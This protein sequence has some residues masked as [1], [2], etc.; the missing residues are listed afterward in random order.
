MLA[1]AVLSNGRNYELTGENGLQLSSTDAEVIDVS[2][3]QVTVRGQ[4]M[5]Q[6]LVGGI[7]RSVCAGPAFSRMKFIEI[8]LSPVSSVEVTLET[9]TLSLAQYSEMLATPSATPIRIE[10][11]HEDGSRTLVDTSDSRIQTVHDDPLVFQNGM[12]DVSQVLVAGIVNFTV[13]YITEGSGIVAES[14]PVDIAVLGVDGVVVS[15]SP[16]PLASGSNDIVIERYEG[17]SIYQQLWLSLTAMIS[18]NTALDITNSSFTSFTTTSSLVSLTGNIVS[19]QSPGNATINA[20]FGSVRSDIIVEVA[21]FEVT[22]T[23]INS[24][25]LPLDAGTLTGAQGQTYIPNLVLVFSDGTEYPNFLTSSGPSI[26]GLIQFTADSNAL[27]VHNTSGVVTIERNSIFQQVMLEAFRGGVRASLSFFVDLLPLLGEVDVEGFQLSSQDPLTVQVYLNADGSDI[28]AIEF[29]AL[30]DPRIFIPQDLPQTTLAN[31]VVGADLPASAMG[32]V[33]YNEHDNLVR[34]GSVLSEPVMGTSRLHVATMRF[35]LRIPLP[36]DFYF[37]II[38][39][40]VNNDSLTFSPIGAPAVRI[41]SAAS[42]GTRPGLISIGPVPRCPSTACTAQECS[43]I[44][45]SIPGDAN[46][47]CTFDLLDVYYTQRTVPELQLPGEGEVGLLPDQLVAMDADVNGMINQA[48]ARLLADS[49]IGLFPLV[50]DLV[51]RPI[52]APGSN[53]VLT[54][55]ITLKNYQGMDVEGSDCLC[56]LRHLPCR[57]CIW[58]SVR[59]H[60]TCKWT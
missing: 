8:D 23:A 6:F 44:R 36:A 4:G 45:P 15:V 31:V 56:L 32:V 22:L 21:D 12:V 24:L 7:D 40:N 26:P 33:S 3:S 35:D 51:V 47:D 11:V 54:I 41:S 14:A 30:F 16:Y 9:S 55:S 58:Q 49:R 20:A 17:T 18:D 10:L 48:D 59:Q 34:F 19:G 29:L 39:V 5:G 42:F 43:A 28:N 38:V 2:D 46:A 37:E 52:D 57:L 53:C 13:I 25:S 60:Y 50:T 27:S 1:E